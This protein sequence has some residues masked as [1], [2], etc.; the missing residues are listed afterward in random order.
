M[1]RPLCVLFLA[2][3]YPRYFG[4]NAGIFLHHLAGHL[5]AQGVVVKV[6]A[7]DHAQAVPGMLDSL[8]VTRFRYALWRHNQQLAYGAGMLPNLRRQP[9]RLL[10]LP[11]FLLAMTYAL[12]RLARQ[13]RPD[14][15]HAHWV[16]PQGLPAVLVGR[17][18]G[19][20]VCLS[21]H[22]S[23]TLGLPDARLARLRRWI[24][25]QAAAWTANS[26]ATAAAL[27]QPPPRQVPVL[28]PMGVDV[29]AFAQ[30]QP[31]PRPADKTVLLYVGRL[32]AKKGV[33]V[34]LAAYARLAPAQRARTVLWLVGT[35]DLQAELA[36]QAQGL[37]VRFWGAVPNAELPAF[38]AA[39]DCVVMPSLTEGQG[40]VAL[41][42]L[43][44]G[45][46]LLA[47]AVDGLAEL[48]RHE[49][50]AYL[51]PPGDVAALQQALHC[52]LDNPDLRAR[53]ATQGQVWVQQHYAWPLIA[54]R[55]IT[56][57]QDIAQVSRRELP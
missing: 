43:A 48:L 13:T 33:A 35:G 2:S 54:A 37:P 51:V 21:A 6:L 17:W 15:I 12:W 56:L 55:F 25:D 1:N 41:E 9:W 53:L 29:Q 14:V 39:A 3:S 47:S 11:L 32:I 44:S 19:I 20:P 57:Y 22:G 23:D 52:L 18:L 4:D 8:A 16:L 36:Q 49:S 34:L 5:Q 7:P 45:R 42:A 40:V 30:A 26:Q 28:I 50:T 38:Y 46:A 31:C 24:V 27:A 10:Q